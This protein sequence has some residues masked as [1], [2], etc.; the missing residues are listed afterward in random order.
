M[1]GA[2][3]LELLGPRPFDVVIDQ[4]LL[5]DLCYH[6]FLSRELESYRAYL[7]S[8]REYQ[9]SSTTGYES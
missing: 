7:L 9:Y 8:S 3:F 2:I 1:E 5:L 6:V 4:R